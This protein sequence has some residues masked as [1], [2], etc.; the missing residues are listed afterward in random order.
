MATW[1]RALPQKEFGG[2]VVTM[3]NSLT[4]FTT[5]DSYL[6]QATF[7]NT[8]S[9][10]V[11]IKVLDKNSTAK[12]VISDQASLQAGGSVIFAW[13]Q[14]IYMKGGITWVCSAA[15]SVDA[16]LYGFQV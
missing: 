10:A 2:V 14:G 3:P 11:T 9:G 16:Q 6:F 8:T 5:T 7:T 13:P 15:A 12:T 4:D 1:L